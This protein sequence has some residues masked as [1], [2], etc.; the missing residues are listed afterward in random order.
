[1]FLIDETRCFKVDFD[2]QIY[3]SSKCSPSLWESTSWI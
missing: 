1:M 2:L 3:A